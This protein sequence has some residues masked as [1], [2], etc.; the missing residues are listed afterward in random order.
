MKPLLLIIR[1][2]P[3]L[4][5]KTRLDDENR[6]MRGRYLYGVEARHAVGYGLPFYAVG[7]NGTT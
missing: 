3:L 7:S 6:F 5:A 4:V 1:Q 2:R